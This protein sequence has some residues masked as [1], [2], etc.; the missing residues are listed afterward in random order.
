LLEGRIESF[1]KLLSK[2]LP[3]NNYGSNSSNSLAYHSLESL[4]YGVSNSKAATNHNG[5]HCRCR[6]KSHQL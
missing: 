2:R 5:D 3:P 1:G 6:G 4:L